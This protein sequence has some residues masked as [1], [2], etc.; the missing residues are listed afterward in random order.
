DACA[1]RVDGWRVG[2][3]ERRPERWR[4]GW[5]VC[6]RIVRWRVAREQGADAFRW[7]ADTGYERE[8]GLRRTGWRSKGFAAAACREVWARLTGC[9]GGCGC[10]HRRR[11]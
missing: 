7:A 8:L 3:F 1:H 2:G 6:L 11:L 9:V 10:E 4:T 5:L